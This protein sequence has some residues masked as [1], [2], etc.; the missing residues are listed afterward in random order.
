MRTDGC[1][2]GV[3]GV[4]DPRRRIKGLGAEVKSSRAAR[5]KVYLVTPYEVC[6]YSCPYTLPNFCGALTLPRST[7]QTRRARPR[8]LFSSAA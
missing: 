4:K 3:C 6:H 1:D 2:E 8:R 5:E 7:T